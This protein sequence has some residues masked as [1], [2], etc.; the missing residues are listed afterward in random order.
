MYIQIS[1]ILSSAT[2]KAVQET[3]DQDEIFQHG[4]HTAGGRA[5]AVK[6]NVQLDES[7]KVGRGVIGTIK[8]SL[9]NHPVFQAAAR[10]Q[11]FARILISRYT[12]GM[13]YGAHVD[14]A[15]I[16]GMRTDLSFT[17]FLS[18]PETY[19]G[20]ALTIQTAGAEDK[21]KLPAGAL[22]L[23]PSTTLHCVDPVTSGTRLA[24]VGWVR[25]LIRS[26]ERRAILFDLDTA[27]AGLGDRLK[28]DPNLDCLA[29]VR[30]NLLRLWVDD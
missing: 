22:I 27:L 9:L 15:M 24:A 28:S 29:N 11:G 6:H 2:L 23:Y 16:D 21:I 30:N 26:G 1:N 20:G 4:A 7:S 18:G 17:L 19:E 12:E 13:S 3:L 14:A 25:S 8:Q 10:P 5:K